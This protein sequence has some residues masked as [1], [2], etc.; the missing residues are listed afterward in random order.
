MKYLMKIAIMGSAGFQPIYMIKNYVSVLQNIYR[1]FAGFD[2]EYDE[3]ITIL[4]NMESHTEAALAVAAGLEG[5]AVE[6]LTTF[7][8]IMQADKV[9]IFCERN[10]DSMQPHI[11][12]ALSLKKNLEVYFAPKETE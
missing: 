3:Y 6:M 4:T 5:F 11:N 9:V 2:P 10:A 12:S 1:P 8:M 7:D